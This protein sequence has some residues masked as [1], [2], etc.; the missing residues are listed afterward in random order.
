MRHDT[1]ARCRRPWTLPLYR[2][3]TEF[4]EGRHTVNGTLHELAPGDPVWTF[5]LRLERSSTAIAWPGDAL[6][7]LCERY[8]PKPS[9]PGD[10]RRCLTA[11]FGTL[12]SSD[13]IGLVLTKLPKRMVAY[14]TEQPTIIQQRWK[15]KFWLGFSAETKTCFDLR[16]PMMR[17]LAEQG[18]TT[19]VC[20]APML[21]AVRLPDDFL[22]ARQMGDRLGR[23][24]AGS[25]LPPDGCAMG[26]CVTR[27]MC[28]SRH[29]LLH[30]ADGDEA[31]NPARSADSAIPGDGGIA[32]TRHQAT[33]GKSHSSILSS[34]IKALS[35]PL[36]STLSDTSSPGNRAWAIALT[37]LLC[38]RPSGP[39]T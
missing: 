4:A 19:F 16:W 24:G 7:D 9:C 13:H 22:N 35:R 3:T 34:I 15:R 12:A 21:D 6:A 37:C 8:E 28:G 29:T 5:P 20:I 38:G 32:A 23:A 36:S 25:L 33:S 30:E 18:W 27:S 17:T 14:I 39:H 2:D 10:P 11:R 26:A 31:T 1:S